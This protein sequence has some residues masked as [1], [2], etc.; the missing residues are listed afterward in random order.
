MKKTHWFNYK[1]KRRKLG[2]YIKNILKSMKGLKVIETLKV[3]F[4]KTTGDKVISKAAYFNSKAQN[5]HQPN[6]NC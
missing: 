4:E 5:N 1:K 6:R 3:E 2:F